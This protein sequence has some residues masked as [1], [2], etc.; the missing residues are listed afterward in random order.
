MKNN[1]GEMSATT[2]FTDV[3]LFVKNVD[4]IFA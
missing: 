4:H 2:T 3:D 1:I